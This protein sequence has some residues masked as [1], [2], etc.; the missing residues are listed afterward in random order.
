M[1]QCLCI[2][3]VDGCYLT[4]VGADASLP[5]TL[6]AE[7]HCHLTAHSVL[8]TDLLKSFLPN[9]QPVNYWSVAAQ[10]MG[11]VPILKTLPR[12]HPLL[13]FT[14]SFPTD[15]L[16]H[17][18]NWNLHG[19][20]HIQ[21]SSGQQQQG[22]WQ[23]CW[24]WLI[25]AL[26]WFSMAV[27]G[28]GYT[29]CRKVHTEASIPATENWDTYLPI[30]TTTHEPGGSSIRGS[31]NHYRYITHT[32]TQHH[33]RSTTNSWIFSEGE[34]GGLGVLT[35][36]QEG[37]TNNQDGRCIDRLHLLNV[38]V[39]ASV[40]F[41]CDAIDSKFAVICLKWNARNFWLAEEIRTTKA[42]INNAILLWT[43]HQSE[44]ARPRANTCM[45]YHTQQILPWTASH[46]IWKAVITE[47]CKWYVNT[48]L[49]RAFYRVREWLEVQKVNN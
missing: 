12:P 8:L 4:D 40:S 32:H 48:L 36:R 6:A 44:H 17:A 21:Y 9:N 15:R 34:R 41:N 22:K 31:T 16:A 38:R 47:K 30:R 29:G 5:E 43:V 26:Q 24:A 14:P 25:K 28:G 10:P 18:I 45:R 27:G 37:P 7:L 1:Y 20:T 39:H 23:R 46:C 49:C 42:W 33:V 11:T 19:M 2:N 3:T 13:S 35:L